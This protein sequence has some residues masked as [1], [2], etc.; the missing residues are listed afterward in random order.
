MI[1]ILVCHPNHGY[2]SIPQKVSLHRLSY[3][4]GW[5]GGRLIFQEC[6]AVIS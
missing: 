3:Q 5:V 2:E 4:H 6:H 1:C